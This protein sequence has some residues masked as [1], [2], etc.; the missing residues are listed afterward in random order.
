MEASGKVLDDIR[1]EGGQCDQGIRICLWELGS[2]D[3][4]KPARQGHHFL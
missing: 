2:C 1:E 4:I 3:S